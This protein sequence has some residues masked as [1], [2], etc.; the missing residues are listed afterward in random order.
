MPYV[1]IVTVQ[2]DFNSAEEA[3]HVIGSAIAAFAQLREAPAATTAQPPPAAIAAST[4]GVITSLPSVPSPTLPPDL[5]ATKR[6]VPQRKTKPAVAAVAPPQPAAAGD[7]PL[8][9][10]AA[11]RQ[12]LRGSGA[13]HI[14]A[15]FRRVT[16]LIAPRVT[17]NAAVGSIA[18]Q[19]VKAGR[20]RRVGEGTYAEA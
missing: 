3:S 4:D 5:P 18:A 14:D 1:R 20:L 6:R 16:P 7:R 12:V 9:V 19:E 8:S 10:A 13:M 17:N 2:A 11:I 15:L